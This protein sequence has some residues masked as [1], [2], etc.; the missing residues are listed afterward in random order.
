VAIDSHGN[1]YVIGSISTFKPYEVYEYNQEGKFVQVFEGKETPGVG[2]S[3]EEGGWGGKP[4]GVTVDLLSEHLLVSIH[5]GKVEG[6]AVK[7]E[8]AV[9]E[10]N[11]A[12]GKFLGQITATLPGAHLHDPREM[13]VDSQGDLY[14]VDSTEPKEEGEP[15]HVIDA[16]GPPGINMPR[17]RIDEASGRTSS[18]AVVS[19]SV[20]SEGLALSACGFQYV[21]EETFSKEGFSTPSVAECEP[22]A[23]KI[24]VDNT[25]H[26]V[27]AKLTGLTS[28]ITYR[29]RLVARTGG[30]VQS[31]S[32]AFTTPHPPRVDSASASNISSTF[33][34]LDAAIDPL[35]ADTTYHFEYDT[36]PYASGEPHGVSVPAPDGDI[37]AGGPTGS[38]EAS[39]AR[40]IGPLRAGTTYYFR[41][42]AENAEGVARGAGVERGVELPEVTF[43]TLPRAVPGLLPDNR[44]Y[45]LVTPPNKGSAEDMFASVETEPGN[46][47]NNDR[48]YPSE[49][50]NAFLLITHAA[51]GSLPGS[52]SNAYV[53]KRGASGWQTNSLASSSLGAQELFA[54]V[55]EPFDLSQVGLGDRFN[56]SRQKTV[57]GPPGGPYTTLLEEEESEGKGSQTKI[58]GAS[59]DLAHVVLES[60]SH[61][62][63]PGTEG[64]VAGSRALYE[65]A[66]GGE[67]TPETSSCTLISGGAIGQC[68]AVLGQGQFTKGGTSHGA[69]SSDGSKVFFTAPDPVAKNYGAGCWDGGTANAPQLYMRSGGETVE[70]SAPEAGVSDACHPAS[71]GC[72]PAIYVGAGEDGSKVFFVTETWLTEDHP[73]GHDLELYM[74]DSTE[75]KLTRVSAGEAASPA[76][77]GGAA[78]NTVPAVASSGS[79]VYFTASGR[80]TSGAPSKPNG[81]VPVYLYRYDTAARTTQYVATVSAVDYP[82]DIPNSPWGGLGQIA[83]VPRANWYTPPGGSYLMFASAGSPT[84]YD[85]NAAGGVEQCPFMDQLGAPKLGLCAEVY[86]YHYEP[87]ASSGGSVVCVSCDPSGARPVSNAFFGHSAGADTSAGGPVRAMSDDGTHVFFDSADPLVPGANNGTLDVFEWEAQGTGGCELAQGCVYLISSGEDRSPSYFL[88]ASPDAQ[89]VFFGT[90]A[91]LVPQDTD[92]A[93]DLYDARVCE[94]ENG[95]PCIQPPT[96]RTGQCEGAAC[97][98][99][100]SPPIEA[101]PVSSTFSGPGNSS[102]EV[103]PA[104]TAKTAAQIRGEKLASALN[105]CKRKPRK[106]RAACRRQA[107]RRYG[108]AAKR[109]RR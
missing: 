14:V 35:G 15:V 21:T 31:G 48:G 33:A 7:G 6:G 13:T 106:K 75:R 96:G 102:G 29:Y 3:T 17:V 55:F 86:R 23:S 85:N 38:A 101:A 62:L 24:P 58:V 81:F 93:G 2:G 49:S 28:G 82:N 30:E 61:T 32:L 25:F 63:A 68:G 18:S 77:A 70:I 42:V 59:R 104:R 84:G 72:H 12:T 11:V 94:P 5:H 54:A 26:A 97:Q 57:L 8:G 98:N 46:F 22:V 50:G 80:L 4:Q 108:R 74:Y 69:V 90:H 44:A 40:Q 105:A 41:V 16:Y 51:F 34:D 19:G 109:G 39:V 45:E 37:G 66:G 65:W 60:L 10:F 79:A 73:A 99:Q 27:Q 67:C 91:K 87:G 92:T 100:P 52:F 64:Q 88:G 95:N 103:A 78:V 76:A 1:I 89:D 53:F 43:T 56:G 107:Q 9:D 36:S 47:F 71:G 83:L 20:D